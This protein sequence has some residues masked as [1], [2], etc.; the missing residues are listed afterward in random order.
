MTAS[1]NGHV[2][3]VDKLL[4]HGATVDLKDNVNTRCHKVVDNRKACIIMS[5]YTL[6]VHNKSESLLSDDERYQRLLC[7]KRSNNKMALVVVDV[8]LCPLRMD[9]VH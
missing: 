8:V 4:Q 6:F 5:I 1:L 7:Y 3:V 9:G 2:E